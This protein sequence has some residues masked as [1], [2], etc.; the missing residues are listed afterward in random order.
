MKPSSKRIK[1]RLMS[2][3]VLCALL[4]CAIGLRAFQL[5]ILEGEKLARM[6][7]RQHL[8]EWL[9]QPKRGSIQD[10]YGETLAASLEGQSV[11]VRPRRLKEPSQQAGPLARALSLDPT[12]VK[13]RLAG[14]KPFVWLKRRITPKEAEKV[15]ALRYEGVGLSNEP[16]RYYPQGWLAGQVL[17][18]VGRDALGLEGIEA[19]YDAYLKGET[20]SP[21]IERDALGRQVLARGVEEVIVPPG[22]DIHLTLD[23]AIQ[24]LAEKQLEASVT[25]FRAKGG[26][27]VVV[28][29]FTG[30]ILAMA[31]YPFF[32]PNKFS[33]HAPQEWRNRAVADS[34]EPGSTFKSILAAA[35][36]EERVLGKDDLF[37][38]EFGKYSFGGRVIHD[39]H[40]YG[41][42]PFS[43]I[44]Q[45]SSNIG[46]TKVAEKL[47]KDAFYKYI[48]R[49]GFGEPTGIDIQGESA[50]MVRHV[51][52]WVPIDLATHAFG[53]GIA[54][55]PLQLAMAYG[56]IANGGFLM[57][58]YIVR[59]IMSPEGKKLVVNEPRVVRRAI[60]E[61][62]AQTLTSILKGVVSEEG[63][64]VLAEVDGFQ[65]AGKTG[66]SQKPDL[67]RGGYSDKRV[68]SFVG[69]VPA[70]DPR[71]VILVLIDEPET[72][73]Y[74]G[75]VAAPA[76]RNI[77]QGALRHL[78]VLPDQGERPAV[79]PLPTPE[80]PRRTVELTP[81]AGGEAGRKVPDFTGL[82]L[83]AAVVKA[84]AARLVLELRG[85]GYVVRQ[86]PSPGT[87]TGTDTKV[88]LHLQG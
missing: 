52:S 12:Q 47:R 9:I 32:N 34:Y 69:F 27:A 44:I 62:T 26:A 63:T 76:F 13:R 17:G 39:A 72:Q 14:E 5:H 86:S 4:F 80:S 50:G 45:H 79:A 25:R 65:V 38:C 71:L 87:Q 88:I 70:D 22:A 75:V 40:K 15:R 10:R 20:S 3:G 51:D 30:E 66:T 78:R 54:V 1:L 23:T 2:A 36:L 24:H 7:E 28:E 37:F 53:Q 77:A 48:R 41:W 35:A 19:R 8:Q 49:F 60:A 83:R 81:V 68:A 6:G 33:R 58:P 73:V 74:G 67:T 29:P 64:G 16:T 61:K 59:R 31:H 84:N 82:G 56:A 43:K 57:R 85:H 42:L 46:A 18:F 11:F 21:L 55:T